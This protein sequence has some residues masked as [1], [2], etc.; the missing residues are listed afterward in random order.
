MRPIVSIVLG[1]LLMAAEG[2]PALAASAFTYQG[3]LVFNGAPAAGSYDFRFILYSA[4]VGGSQIGP[5]VEVP[6]VAVTEGVFTTEIDF[7]P[8]FGSAGY[9][10]DIAVKPSGASTYTP[11][12]PRQAVTPAPRRCRGDPPGCGCGAPGRLSRAGRSDA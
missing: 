4:E 9:W 5:I 7:G 6:A 2:S 11:L 10:L 3:E 1:L 8:V 12:S